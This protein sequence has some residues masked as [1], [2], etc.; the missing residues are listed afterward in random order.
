MQSHLDLKDECMLKE[1]YVPFKVVY[2]KQNVVHTEDS[3]KEVFQ[4]K[5]RD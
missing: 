4:D 1:N 2:L 5:G 3:G